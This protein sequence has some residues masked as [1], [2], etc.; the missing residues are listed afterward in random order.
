[1]AECL[2]VNEEV[3]GSIPRLGAMMWCIVIAATLIVVMG[4]ALLIMKVIVVIAQLVR[5]RPCQGRGR[6]F[7]SLLP[8]HAVKKH[9]S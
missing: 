4:I 2:A 5:A 6:G 9:T 7:E 3:R 8:L 1:M